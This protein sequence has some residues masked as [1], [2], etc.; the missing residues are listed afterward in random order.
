MT[1]SSFCSL[2]FLSKSRR[3]AKVDA[4]E[5]QSAVH[6]GSMKEDVGSFTC[7]GFGATPALL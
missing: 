5:A 3:L 4:L 6:V 7:L 2:I 1:R